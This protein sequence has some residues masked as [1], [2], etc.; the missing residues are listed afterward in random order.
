MAAA[1]APMPGALAVPGIE[2]VHLQ[3]EH[4]ISRLQAPDRVILDR[5]GIDAQNARM[6]ALDPTLHDLETLPARL[7]A[8]QVRDAIGK[9]SAPPARTLYDA[10]GRE[11][12]GTQL[13]AFADNL[14]L[15]AIPDMRPLE[16]GLVTRRADL[17]AFPTTERV[18][19]SVGDTDIDRFQESALFPGDAVAVMHRSRD[20]QWLFVA[21]QRYLAWIEKRFVAVGDAGQVFGYARRMPY[22]IVTGATVSTAYT[23]EQPQVSR[24]QLDMGVRVPVL[25]DWPADTPVNGQ[26]PYTSHVIELPIRDDDGRL[27]LVPALLPRNADTRA[28]Y[29]PLTARNL[30]LQSFKFLGERY[31]WGHAY[32]AR[33]CSGFVS[34]VYR[35]FGVLLPRNTSA[36]AVS[37]ALDRVPLTGTDGERKRRRAIAQLQVGDLIYIPG[38]VMMAI[39]RENGLTYVIHDTAGGSWRDGDGQRV[40][41]RLNGVAVTPLEPLLA[42]DAASYIDRITSIQRIRP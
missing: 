40:Q 10:Q 5:A 38:H 30:L 31:G 12:T 27:R 4:W 37:P 29:L 24:L 35:S 15:D 6:Q 21:S 20:G 14:A 26:H 36:Q 9:L 23:P 22:R 25:A 16:Y 39:G 41:A 3:A 18:F 42:G 8:A 13:A 28:D 11:L 33:D 1:P 19:S 2:E 34:E 17:R 32:D 7:P